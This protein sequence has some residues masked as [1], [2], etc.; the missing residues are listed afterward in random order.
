VTAADPERGTKTCLR[1]QREQPIDNYLR[2][3]RGY[4]RVCDDCREQQ[5]MTPAERRESH[6]LS[7]AEYR[8]RRAA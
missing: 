8:Q 2:N 7:K 5:L 6:R 3:H 1:C 4:F